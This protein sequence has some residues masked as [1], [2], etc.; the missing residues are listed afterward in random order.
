MYLATSHGAYQALRAHF[1]IILASILS[2][3][4]DP[5]SDSF[6]VKEKMTKVAFLF[7]LRQLFYYVLYIQILH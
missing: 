2:S 4:E 6:W 3:E 5:K 7:Q 1:Q